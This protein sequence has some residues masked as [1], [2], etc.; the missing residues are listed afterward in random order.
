MTAALRLT[1]SWDDGHPLDLRVAEI[2]AKHGF[3]GTFYV[4]CHNCEGRPVL[5][6]SELRTLG[7][8][9]EIGGHSLDHVPLIGLAVGYRDHQLRDSKRRI[10]NELGHPITG[11]CYPGG[12]HDRGVRQAVR[13][14]GFRYARTVTNLSTDPPHDRFRVATTIQ[15]FP[16]QPITYLKNYT[17]RG[18]WGERA[19]PLAMCLRHRSIDACLEALLELAAARGGVFHLWGHSWE[20]EDR[21]LWG[22]LDRF[23]RVAERL[24]AP[25]HRL[26]NAG[27]IAGDAAG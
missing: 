20:L 27:L 19:L 11:F 9:F 8:S 16:H 23:L 18:S 24:V 12:M 5:S 1:T 22:V 3:S 10:E 26:S 25:E 21:G 6:T 13:E 2:L 17:W 7:A 14:A 4:P 15:L